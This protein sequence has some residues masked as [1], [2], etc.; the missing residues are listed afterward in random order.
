MCCFENLSPVVSRFT[1]V[2]ALRML[3]SDSDVLEGW[4]AVEDGLDWNHSGT[5][6]D[7]D[8]NMKHDV[9]LIDRRVL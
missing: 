4:N 8:L 1:S 6:S 2:L 5:M 9:R 3:L 7:C